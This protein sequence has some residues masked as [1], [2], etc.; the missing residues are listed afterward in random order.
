MNK[1][2]LRPLS[3]SNQ[4]LDKDF[5][6]DL[7][8]S[9]KEAV[10]YLEGPLLLI[11]GAGS[12]K[13]K[14]LVYRVA[15]LVNQGVPPES[16]L[17]LTFTRKASQE[18]LKRASTLLDS[19]CEKVSGGT[20]HAFANIMLRKYAEKIGYTSQF[21]ILDQGDA[22]DLVQLIRKELGYGKTDKRFP[23]KNTILSII[24]KSL[25]TNM[26]IGP[27][28]QKEYSHF[29]EFAS[30]IERIGREYQRR[31]QHMLVMDYDDLLLKFVQLLETHSDVST[32][33]STQ[34]KYIMVDEYQDTNCVQARMITAL[35]QVHNNI[36][37]VG[38]DSQSIY[39]FRGANFKNIMDFPS[40]YKNTKLIKLEQNY[41]SS[42]SILDL[43]N[44]LISQAKE[45]FTKQLFSNEGQGTSPIY[46]ETSSENKQSKFICQK[47]LELREEGVDLRHIAVLMRSGWHSND[48]EIEL[49]AQGIPFT[50]QGGFKFI[51]SSHIKDIIAFL[52]VAYN[53]SDQ[54]S[55]NRVFLLLEGVGPSAAQ[56]IYQRILQFIYMPEAIDLGPFYKKKFYPELSALIQL[57]M[58]T[59]KT[60]TPTELIDQFLTL[61]LPTF[62]LKYD[63][64]TKRQSDI[65][66]LK[67][68][69]ERFTTLE[70]FL[71]EISL[72][73][74][75]QS[76]VDSLPQSTDDE[77]ITLSTIHSAKGLEWHSVFILSA[78]DGYIPSFQSLGD[79]AQIEE[80]RR[81]LYVALT[82]AQK[83]LYILKPNLNFSGSNYFRFSGM[84]FSKVSR[85]LEEGGL[86]ETYTQK[87]AVEDEAPKYS[88][89]KAQ[90]KSSNDYYDD[91]YDPSDDHSKYY[92]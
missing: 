41:R 14:T 84:Q 48:L 80:E 78:V 34:F 71:A 13:T 89:Y 56:V 51:E 63:D 23:K 58:V 6:K 35:T 40:L 8:P 65:D 86:L 66:S 90:K 79:L 38:D 29:F 7:N 69:S 47:I 26:A 73:P 70:E 20:F 82:R 30:D 68:I 16:I 11:A 53:P 18:M 4:I 2:I 64:F 33:L 27:L 92:F 87:W 21:T 45:K 52:K 10:H 44:A 62:K 9:Q 17:L 12:G 22:E 85:F 67:L 72:D 74:P 5:D 46:I 31:K 57:A 37:V 43:T 28:I 55:W 39:S 81:L 75:T 91:F 50:K 61:Y 54:V 19:R 77:K 25:N 36:M 59:A 1:Y 88:S 15:N 83:N 60:L 32:A 3:T 42:Q 76:H 24:S 49:Q